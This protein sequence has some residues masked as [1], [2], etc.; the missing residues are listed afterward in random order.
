[1]TVKL[2]DE[3]RP[4][5]RDGSERHEHADTS[6]LRF[7]CPGCIQRVKHDQVRAALPDMNRGELIHLI[8]HGDEWE[9]K[10]ADEELTRR[11]IEDDDE[12]AI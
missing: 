7:G 4:A 8:N 9:S 3:W 10:V 6:R 12:W 11:Q 2:V 1:M 5:S